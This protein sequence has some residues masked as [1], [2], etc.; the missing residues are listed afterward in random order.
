MKQNSLKNKIWLYFSIFSIIILGCLWFF[1][2]VFLDTYYE[3]QKKF[4]LNRIAFKI[5][6]SYGS[7][8]FETIL[9]DIS[10]NNDV[11]IEL[12]KSDGNEYFTGMV[13]K[14]CFINT[15]FNYKKDFINSLEDRKKYEFVNDRF[16]NKTLVYALKL[17]DN[18]NVFINVSLDP[19]S[20]TT[21]ILANQF[22]YVTFIVLALAF[23]IAY[24]VSSN[25]S[26]PIVK[27]KKGASSMSKGNYDVI[28]DTNSNITEIDELASTLNSACLEL[29][30]TE[31]VRREFLA[32]VSHDLKTPLTMIKAY[33]EMVRDLT[34]NDKEKRE[35]NLNVIIEE[36]ERLNL[37]VGDLLELSKIQANVDLLNLESF[38]L[39]S[40]IE[41]ILS[42][43]KYLEETKNYKFIYD[44]SNS[45][46]T[47]GDKK[48]IEQVIYNLIS[49]AVN[50]AG[51]DKSVIISVKEVVT[52]YRIEVINHGKVIKEDEIDHIWDKYYKIDKS[53]KRDVVGTGLGL[54]IVKNILEKHHFVYGVTSNIEEGTI[55]YFVVPKEK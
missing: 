46:N 11:C 33:A 35:E 44:N 14:G 31:E 41:T 39:N 52:G 5:E 55:F 32:N 49:N 12:V 34:Y 54:S 23:V 24:F 42:R 53:H 43:F 22:V 8:D 48:K 15:N 2:I 26:K 4:Q 7:D 36:T 30:K 16:N 18:L 51:K 50:Y 20:S 21:K 29:S 25:I 3:Y 10:F 17:D 13:S 40:M 28:F 38:D 6:K 19:V 45:I 27:L 37:L 47:I 1:Q 9:D